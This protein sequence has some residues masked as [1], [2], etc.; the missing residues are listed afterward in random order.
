MPYKSIN[1]ISEELVD[2]I[3]LPKGLG[4]RE[5]S[6]YTAEETSK[7]LHLWR[8]RQ[9]EG[10]VVFKF[11]Y[12]VCKDK[13][14]EEATYPEGMF[15]NLRAAG[16]TIPV[17]ENTPPEHAPSADIAEQG[18]GGNEEEE[19]EDEEEDDEEDDVLAYKMRKRG[20]SHE[21]PVAETSDTT[22]HSQQSPAEKSR[23][24]SEAEG[25]YSEAEGREPES[26][27]QE[28]EP[29]TQ[30][31]KKRGR[32]VQLKNIIQDTDGSES[33][34]ASTSRGQSH[35][36]ESTPLGSSPTIAP[37]SSP[38]TTIAPSSSPTPYKR[39][40]PKVT[41]ESRPVRLKTMTLKA[42]AAQVPKGRKNTTKKQ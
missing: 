13:Q 9:R 36:G 6:T 42:Q 29:A 32:I 3:Y 18:D 21:D 31:R 24:E 37:S 12:I 33:P 26:E 14:T 11:K 22:P 16:S 4:I 40:L 20:A 30:A 23:E 1:D 8:A 28:S 41:E 10:Q 7:I 5:P 17:D 19:E 38:T 39:V 2:P 27:G 15:N 34:R 25:E 35:S